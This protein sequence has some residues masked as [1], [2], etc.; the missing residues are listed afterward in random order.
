MVYAGR[1]A[2]QIKAMRAMA[3]LEMSKIKNYDG[4]EKAINHD[5][6]FAL[7]SILLADEKI[8]NFKIPVYVQNQL[9]Q[10]NNIIKETFKNDENFNDFGNHLIYKQL[11]Q[12]RAENPSPIKDAIFDTTF[13][14]S[15]IKFIEKYKN[16]N[17]E[18]FLELNL[19]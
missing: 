10:Y 18:S 4:L 17:S 1:N 15:T 9:D 19:K 12:Y 5:L 7:H 8:A 2:D 3:I 6:D 13:Q 14:Q 16:I 11:A